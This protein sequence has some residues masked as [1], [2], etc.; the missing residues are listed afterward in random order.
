MDTI[1]K[2]RA[3]SEEKQILEAGA[4]RVGLS[5]SA[6]LRGVS[7]SAAGDVRHIEGSPEPETVQEQVAKVVAAKTIF[8]K[9]PLQGVKT[10]QKMRASTGGMKRIQEI[11]VPDWKKGPVPER[12]G[13]TPVPKRGKK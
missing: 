9:D 4:K 5:L 11:P 6:W 3:T 1:I 2:F 8:K 7:L 10:I 12:S 13:F